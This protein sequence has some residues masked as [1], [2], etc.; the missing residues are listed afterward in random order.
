MTASS[1]IFGIVIGETK[2]DAFVPLA[3]CIF[4]FINTKFYYVRYV[5]S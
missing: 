4:Y 3:G 5:K 2:T 1:R